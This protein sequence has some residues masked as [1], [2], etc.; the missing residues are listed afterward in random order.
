MNST[1]TRSFIAG[2]GLTAALTGA[3]CN[4]HNAAEVDRDNGR[5]AADTAKD[6]GHEG[7]TITVTGCLQR[8]TSG[9]DTYVLTQVNSPSETPV[10][11]AGKD[12]SGAPVQREQMR[13]AKHSYALDNGD[14]D[15]MRDM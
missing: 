3:A 6:R 11:T 5:L 9:I 1:W 2:C 15:V 7:A 13:E 14:K 8:S 12:A 10:A 4:R